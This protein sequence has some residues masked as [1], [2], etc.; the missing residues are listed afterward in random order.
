MIVLAVETAA[1]VGS[2]AV[3]TPDGVRDVVLAERRRHGTSIGPACQQVLKEAGIGPG[4]IDAVVVGVGP[5]SYTGA[6]I[7]V[8]FAKTLAFTLDVRLIGLSGLMAVAAD[9]D[10]AAGDEVVVVT[11]GHKTRVYGAVYRAVAD[12]GVPEE[13][14]APALW[15]EDD[16]RAAHRGATVVGDGATGPM[17]A[18]ATL[19]RLGAAWLT[20][21]RASSDIHALEPLYLQPSAPER[22]ASGH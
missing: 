1:D 14:S 3:W 10:A 11:P 7:A 5:G 19:A 20:E 8:A 16:L 17:V 15:V 4:D 21:G 13:I 22:K 2:V 18:A 6:R 9:S 12:R